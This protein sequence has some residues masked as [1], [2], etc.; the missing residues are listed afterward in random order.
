ML[1]T[2]ILFLLSLALL[3]LTR[4]LG[5][6][7]FADSVRVENVDDCI[8][9]VVIGNFGARASIVTLDADNGTGS[10][11]FFHHHHITKFTRLTSKHKQRFIAS[12][13]TQQLNVEAN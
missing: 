3:F 5:L 12:D 6:C 13:E 8:M 10:Q 7:C 9:T 1:T 4:L 2:G 11:K